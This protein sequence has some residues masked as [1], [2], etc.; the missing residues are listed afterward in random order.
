[1]RR[2][3]WER[4]PSWIGGNG[5]RPELIV[6]GLRNHFVY[7]MYDTEGACLYVG[8]T[9]RPTKRWREHCSNNKQL[10]AAVAHKR[11]AGPYDYPTARR[12]EREQQIKLKPVYMK[13]RWRVREDAAS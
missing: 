1:M 13:T 4:E 12:I 11:M 2:H 10:V 5:K 3:W 9:R 6:P 7:W 8:C